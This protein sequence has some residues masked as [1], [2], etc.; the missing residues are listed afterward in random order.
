M[1]YIFYV[2]GMA[3]VLALILI[4]WRRLRTTV[5]RSRG[6]LDNVYLG[7]KMFK[8]S[9]TKIQ[10]VVIIIYL[11]LVFYIGVV[12]APWR[13]GTSELRVRHF[14]WGNRYPFEIDSPKF[15]IE[16]GISTLI[17]GGIFLIVS[18]KKK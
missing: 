17:F 3:L 6:D 4:E 1:K 14:L 9:L 12:S 5:G 15:L 16:I 2:L 7:D 10:K 13:L 18:D 8:I 11:L